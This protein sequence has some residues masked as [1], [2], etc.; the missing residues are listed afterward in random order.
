MYAESSDVNRHLIRC[1]E[2]EIL[3]MKKHGIIMNAWR[4]STCYTVH[5]QYNMTCSV[6]KVKTQILC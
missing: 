2:M 6:R 4:K 1:S 3:K 5:S